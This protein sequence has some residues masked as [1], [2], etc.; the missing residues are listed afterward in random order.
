MVRRPIAVFVRAVTPEALKEAAR[1]KAVSSAQKPSKRVARAMLSPRQ[2][3]ERMVEFW[4]NHF[5]VFAGKGLDRLWIGAYEVQAIRPHVLGRFR[6]LLGATAKHPAM[7]FYLDNWQ[8]TAPGSAG[9]RGNFKGLNENY[10]RELMELHTLGVDGGYTQADV[11]ALARILTGWGLGGDRGDGDPAPAPMARLIAPRPN[12]MRAIAHNARAF[13]FDP[14]RHDTADKRFLGHVIRGRSG[15]A[16]IQEGEE[17]LDMLARAPATARHISFQL[18]QFF[19]ADAPDDGA[20]RRHGADIPELRRRHPR[21][22]AHDDREPRIPR[23]R[24]FRYALQDALSVCRFGGARVRR[25]GAQHQAALRHAHAARPAAV[26][27]SDAGRVQVHR[28]S[29][30]Q[31]RCDHAAH[32]LRGGPGRRPSAAWRSTPIRKT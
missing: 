11:I 28:R 26:W 14:D 32:F 1:A 7:L 29:V 16:G 2:L 17:A 30:A 6:D 13:R 18:A 15:E 27:V 10:A 23:S 8:N 25:S 24:E 5:N 3:E 12:L 20:G 31:S 19:V 9:A 22:A 21:G 4:F